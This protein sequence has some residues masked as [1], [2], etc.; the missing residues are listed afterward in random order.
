VGFIIVAIPTK[1]EEVELVDEA[2]LFEEIDGAVDGD[3]VDGRVHLLGAGE[4]LIDVEML[5]GVVHDL[6]NDAALAGEADAFGAKS[7]LQA[8]CG[9]GGIKAFA[10]GDTMGRNGRHERVPE[11]IF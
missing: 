8:A 11:S 9:L 4:D 3:Q 2:F 5:L 6:E 1:M 10:G 7:F